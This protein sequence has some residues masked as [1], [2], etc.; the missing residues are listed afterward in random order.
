MLKFFKIVTVNL[1]L[2]VFVF[3]ICELYARSKF[4]GPMTISKLDSKSVTKKVEY[5]GLSKDDSMYAWDGKSFRPQ[6]G[7]YSIN[8]HILTGT[9][10][11]VTFDE[12]GLRVNDQPTEG[13]PILVIGD[14]TAIQD[15]LKFNYTWGGRL[16]DLFSKK[17]KVYNAAVPSY[18]ISAQ[19][20]R[21]RE[22]VPV[23]KPKVIILG[24]YLNDLTSCC[25]SRKFL[26]RLPF[27]R[28]VFIEELDRKIFWSMLGFYNTSGDI[29]KN[30]L[31]S[32]KL[33]ILNQNSFLTLNQDAKRLI[34]DNFDDWGNVWST[35]A[36][37]Q[38]EDKIS[39]LKQIANDTNA[40]LLVVMFPHK[41]QLANGIL[42]DFPQKQMTKL[43]TRKNIDFVNLLSVFNS[44]KIPSSVF[45]DHCHLKD[46]TSLQIA[47]EVGRFIPQ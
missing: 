9:N 22:V 28:S 17:I 25:V 5:F 31:A 20:N 38:F 35:Q 40:K 12:N 39:E 37:R 10:S 7:Q 33:D 11:L 2:L 46:I 4:R 42:N 8:Q 3:T 14:S 34:L 26:P 43:L 21:L 1:V 24:W 44:S 36:V 23:I 29:S 16:Q 41:D 19:I 30:D 27:M 47:T 13:Q 32:Y 18:G 6:Q 45:F 15:Y